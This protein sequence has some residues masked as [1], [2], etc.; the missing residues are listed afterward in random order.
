MFTRV[1]SLLTIALVQN[2]K[3]DVLRAS[4]HLSN[5]LIAG[6]EPASVVTDHVSESFIRRGIC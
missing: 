1:F 3:A 5:E 4:R 2:G 6:Y